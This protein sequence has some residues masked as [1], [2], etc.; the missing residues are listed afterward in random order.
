MTWQL[1]DAKN[2]LSK[3]VNTSITKGPQIISRR[4]RNT[5][6]LISYEEYERLTSKKKTVKEALMAI[7]ISQLDLTRDKSSSGRT[8]P[9]ELT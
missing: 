3:V 4:G 5:A 8:T 2:K 1:Q 9:L 7:D 6:V